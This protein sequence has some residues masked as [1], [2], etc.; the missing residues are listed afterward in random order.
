ME[1]YCFVKLLAFCSETAHHFWLIF[2]VILTVKA[3]TGEDFCYMDIGDFIIV[4]HKWE[5]ELKVT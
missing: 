1:S 2:R 3:A 4:G 5:I